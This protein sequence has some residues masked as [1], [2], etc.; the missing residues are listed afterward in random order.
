MFSWSTVKQT[1]LLADPII[2][3]PKHMLHFSAAPSGTETCL[4]DDFHLPATGNQQS[5]AH[6]A[7]PQFHQGLPPAAPSRPPRRQQ[8]ST[9]GL[10]SHSRHHG[11]FW[12]RIC[13]H[14]DASQP[15]LSV[16]SMVSAWRESVMSM[17][18]AAAC[19]GESA[20]LLCCIWTWCEE[21]CRE[22]DGEGT[23]EESHRGSSLPQLIYSHSWEQSSCSGST[24]QLEVIYHPMDFDSWHCLSTVWSTGLEE[25]GKKLQDLHACHQQKA[26]HSTPNYR[27]SIFMWHP[28]VLVHCRLPAA[29]NQT[30]LCP[31]ELMVCL[32]AT[33]GASKRN[34][35]CSASLVLKYFRTEN[36]PTGRLLLMQKPI[37][38]ALLTRNILY[39]NILLKVAWRERIF[40]F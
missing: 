18:S 2:C 8:F 24:Q 11:P 21:T 17:L 16:P 35:A 5:P 22:S 12:S 25:G 31:L 19:G 14:T 40:I 30:T 34:G 4:S 28:V 9:E 38:R 15:H 13:Y 23:S 33:S 1:L 32:C 10:F 20:K 39:S 37:Q 6:Q 36:N 26:K 27:T 7:G 29:L 3:G